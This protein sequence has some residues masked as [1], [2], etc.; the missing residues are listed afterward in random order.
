M[1]GIRALGSPII[2]AASRAMT[3]NGLSQRRSDR[4]A[5]NS[6]QF[7]LRKLGGELSLILVADCYFKRIFPPSLSIGC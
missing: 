5:F 2:P 6:E 1:K 4:Y 3:N 7:S